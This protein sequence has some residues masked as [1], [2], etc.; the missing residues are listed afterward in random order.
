MFFS[1]CKKSSEQEN[2][3]GETILGRCRENATKT[4]TLYFTYQETEQ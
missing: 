4:Q 1:T 3:W 2:E